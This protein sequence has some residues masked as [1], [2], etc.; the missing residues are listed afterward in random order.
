MWIYVGN[1]KFNCSS[2][3]LLKYHSVSIYSPSTLINLF[4]F[5]TNL[6]ISLHYESAFYNRNHSRAVIS[7]SSLMCNRRPPKWPQ[8]PTKLN[9]MCR[10]FPTKCPQ[11]LLCPMCAERGWSLVL[12]DNTS[13]QISVWVA[14]VILGDRHLHNNEKLEIVVH[15]WLRVKQPDF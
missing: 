5:D 14:E 7:T 8:Q 9:Q 1:E 3:L 2:I 10:K 15:E 11:S 13:R 12:K 6:Q 4:H